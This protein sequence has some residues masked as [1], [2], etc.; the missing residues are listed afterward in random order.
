MAGICKVIALKKSPPGLLLALRMIENSMDEQR[1]WTLLSRL[2]NS[3]NWVILLYK[4]LVAWNARTDKTQAGNYFTKDC[5]ISLSRFVVP[6]A[7]CMVARTVLCHNT[8][9]WLSITIISPP[10]S[11][12]EACIFRRGGYEP[13]LGV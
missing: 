13:E 7:L 2:R 11:A 10:A 9:Q 12:E 6:E 4:V 1:D 3:P 5:Y 8:Q